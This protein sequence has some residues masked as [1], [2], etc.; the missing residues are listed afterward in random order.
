[1]NAAHTRVSGLLFQVVSL[2]TE[3]AIPVLLY[4]HLAFASQLHSSDISFSL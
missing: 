2:Q 3:G 1:M 4:I